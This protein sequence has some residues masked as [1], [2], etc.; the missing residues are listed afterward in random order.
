MMWAIRRQYSGAVWY[1]WPASCWPETTSHR[2]NSASS[3]P[4]D[5]LVTRPTTSACALTVFQFWNCGASSILMVFWMKAAGSIGAN[6]PLRLRLLVMTPATSAPTWPSAGEPAPKFGIA[7]GIGWNEFGSIL[8]R[9]AKEDCTPIIAT[10]DPVAIMKRRRVMDFVSLIGSLLSLQMSH[11]VFQTESDANVFPGLV[12]LL[13]Q[14]RIGLALHDGACGALAH[15]AAD[16]RRRSAHGNNGGLGGQGAIR[17]HVD[18]DVGLELVGIHAVIG[19]AEAA[20][21]RRDK[22]ALPGRHD[23]LRISAVGAQ[24]GR[25]VERAARN[26]LARRIALVQKRR[27]LGLIEHALLLRLRR[28][29]CGL[30]FLLRLRLGLRLLRLLGLQRLRNRIDLGGI[31]LLV[32]LLRLVLGLVFSL[33]G[34]IRFFLNRLF[35]RLRR[36]RGG[37]LLLGHLADRLVDGLRVGDL[38]DQRL[39]LVLLAVLDAL[40][41]LG[42]LVGG[43]DVDRKR[44]LRDF[45]R[46]RGKGYQSPSEHQDVEHN[47]RSQ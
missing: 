23:V 47:R 16:R 12:L 27:D 36:S 38:L 33:L 35:D 42:E 37:D 30:R 5:C 9:C 44:F 6:R 25:R 39:R 4:S 3:R 17:P 1:F 24:G 31:G 20:S 13:G 45:I 14:E 34:R 21:H 18:I 43:D 28:R 29:R 46:A 40:R 10:V 7:I 26:R 11:H 15:G 41:H 8:S 19:E 2:R 22:G 32:G